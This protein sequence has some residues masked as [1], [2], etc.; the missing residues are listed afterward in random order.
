[1]DVRGKTHDV[2]VRNCRIEDSGGAKQ[3]IGIRMAADAMRTGIED[4]TFSGLEQS[5][6]R[7]D[8]KTDRK[9]G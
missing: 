2:V 1:M 9:G 4:N 5:V 8:A 6:M 3:K 7:L